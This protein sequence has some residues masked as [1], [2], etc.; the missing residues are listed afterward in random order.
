MSLLPIRKYNCKLTVV[1]FHSRSNHWYWYL[2]QPYIHLDQLWIWWHD[3]DLMGGWC[4]FRCYRCLELPG[5]GIY[6]SQK[7]YIIH[8]KAFYMVST[9]CLIAAAS[10][11][12]LVM[13]TQSPNN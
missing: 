4:Y 9:H 7:V 13:N 1:V 8:Y 12:I 2:F 11:N 5:A 3:A 6:A 10:K